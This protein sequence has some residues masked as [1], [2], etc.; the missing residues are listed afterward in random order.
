MNNKNSKKLSVG[1]PI[2]LEINGFTVLVGKNNRQNDYITTKVANKEDLWFHVK[3]FHGSH[4]ILRTNGKIPD[5]D[6]LY[7]CANLAKEHSKAKQSSN[8]S[9]DYTYIKYVKK[10]SGSKPGMV[11]YTH[12]KS[13]VVK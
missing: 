6:T 5:S 3:D 12:E 4:V 2:K 13:I 8:I 7:K 9:V 1:E 10:P 11:I